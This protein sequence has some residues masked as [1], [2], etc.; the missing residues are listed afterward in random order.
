MIKDDEFEIALHAEG[1]GDCRAG[2][3][4][5]DCR[6]WPV[7]RPSVRSLMRS[8]TSDEA[9]GGRGLQFCSRLLRLAPEVPY[10]TISLRIELWPITRISVDRLGGQV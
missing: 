9:A 2:V 8:G 5:L 1:G 3:H 10:L 7:S 4:G 6:R